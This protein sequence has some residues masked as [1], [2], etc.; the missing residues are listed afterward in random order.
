MMNPNSNLLSF[1]EFFVTRKLAPQ[2][3]L[4]SQLTGGF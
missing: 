1:P 3:S 2:M 4:Q